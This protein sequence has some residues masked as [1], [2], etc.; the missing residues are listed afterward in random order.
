MNL[1]HALIVPL[2]GLLIGLGALIGGRGGQ[3]LL[4][5]GTVGFGGACILALS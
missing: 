4:I 5:V 2:S 1:L 3:V